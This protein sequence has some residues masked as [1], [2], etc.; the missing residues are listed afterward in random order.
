MFMVSQNQKGCCWSLGLQLISPWFAGPL[1]RGN[2]HSRGRLLLHCYGHKS[3][4]SQGR[5]STSPRTR[6][7]TLRRLW[8]WSWWMPLTSIQWY[9]P[10]HNIFLSTTIQ[11]YPQLSRTIC[12]NPLIQYH[13]IHNYSLLS[14][15]IHTFPILFTTFQKYLQLSST[16]PLSS[17]IHNYPVLLQRYSPPPGVKKT[18]RLPKRD[19]LLP[20]DLNYIHFTS[21]R[22]LSFIL[23]FRDPQS[24][25]HIAGTRQ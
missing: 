18:R 10:N 4:F 12:N 3:P 16:I 8:C 9:P 21:D 20:S 17:F 23:I 7:C 5:R 14:R 1:F 15:T 2:S 11:H 13:I 24:F 6:C 22:F 19:V 25:V